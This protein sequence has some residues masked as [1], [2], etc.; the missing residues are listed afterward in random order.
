MDARLEI[1]HTT[2]PGLNCSVFAGPTLQ[3]CRMP[4]KPVKTESAKTTLARI[5]NEMAMPRVCASARK[6][7]YHASGWK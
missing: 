5:K 6:A 3:Y 4:K 1:T 7:L 2:V